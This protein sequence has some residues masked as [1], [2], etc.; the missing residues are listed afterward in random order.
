MTPL[1]AIDPQT[2]ES[3][4]RL[5]YRLTG[6][7]LDEKKRSLL[8]G[9]LRREARSGGFDS[10]EAY[11]ATV[12]AA[13][14]GSAEADAFVDAVTT[15][16]TSFFRTQS[17]WT[18]LWNEHLPHLSSQ[19]KPTKWW[20]GACSSGEE[21]ASIAML[22]ESYRQKNAGFRYNVVATD[23]SPSMVA[24][25]SKQTF[26]TARVDAIR[27]PGSVVPRQHFV[28]TRE[29]CE[30]SSGLRRNMTFRRHNL[31]DRIG[32]STFDVALV[33]NVIIYFT[34]EDQKKVLNLAIESLVSGGLLITGEAESPTQL[35]DRLKF[36]APCVYRRI[37]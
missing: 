7:H 3:L 21:P 32:R 37:R 30:L 31:F 36:V 9:R 18:Y 13:A 14:P 26:D 8:L 4:V 5:C 23:I 16:K 25:A 11:L 2:Y 20:S 17:V 15:N 35:T 1:C 22:C 27:P 19:A 33:R 34:K 24:T 12:E 6:I 29:G 28:K 10:Y